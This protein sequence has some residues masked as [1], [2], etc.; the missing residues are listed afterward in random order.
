MRPSFA[1]GSLQVTSI[2]IRH[3]CTYLFV[4]KSAYFFIRLYMHAWMQGPWNWWKFPLSKICLAKLHK[5]ELLRRGWAGGGNRQKMFDGAAGHI[6]I[7][8]QVSVWFSGRWMPVVDNALADFTLLWYVTHQLS[9]MDFKIEV[10]RLKRLMHKTS[11]TVSGI[12]FWTIQ[13]RGKLGSWNNSANHSNLCNL[14]RY[15]EKIRWK[16]FDAFYLLT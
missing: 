6:R 3:V 9:S 8:V 10:K 15:I 2:E 1:Y 7:M 4:V 12:F 5:V 11:H 16:L 13:I 14:P